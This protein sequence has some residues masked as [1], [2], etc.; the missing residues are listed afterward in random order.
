MSAEQP[1]PVSDLMGNYG[2]LPEVHFGGKAYK[3]GLPCPEVVAYAERM[4]PVLA[5]ANLRETQEFADPSE[6]AKEEAAIRAAVR[7]KEYGFGRPLFG[8]VVG[9]ADGNVLIL[10]ACLRLH[11]PE[12]TVEAV[13]AM[14]RDDTAAVELE[15]ALEV[16]APAF[17]RAAADRVD[18]PKRERDTLAE[19]MAAEALEGVLSAKLRRLTLLASN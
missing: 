6:Y 14:L 3:V 11:A 13:R 17:F 19:R 7:G 2:P 18:A 12:V 1:L 8:S 9:G 5:L 16:V 10:W 4:V 15:A